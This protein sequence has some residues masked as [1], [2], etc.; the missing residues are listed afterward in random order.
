MEYATSPMK[1]PLHTHKSVNLREIYLF[2][3]YQTI[4]Y[5]RKLKLKAFFDKLLANI[6][7]QFFEQ[8]IFLDK[9]HAF[10]FIQFMGE[11]DTLLKAYVADT[12][13]QGRHQKLALKPGFV[14]KTQIEGF[15]WEKGKAYLTNPA[16]DP[17]LLCAVN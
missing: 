17:E 7:R 11:K 1:V 15:F 4:K 5:Q 13:I 9:S 14:N 2:C 16:F 12:A 8:P 6:D 3:P 10:S